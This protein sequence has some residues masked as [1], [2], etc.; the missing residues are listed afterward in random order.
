MNIAN[1][2]KI[3][4]SSTGVINDL[5]WQKKQIGERVYNLGVGEPLMST[6]AMIVDAAV[7]AIKMGWTHYSPVAG[8]PELRQAA[9]NWLNEFYSADYFV[10]EVLIT[11]GGKYALYL[12]IQCLVNPGDE[13]VI[14][15]PFWVSYQSMAE[16]AGGAVKIVET[17]EKSDWKPVLEDIKLK[18]NN[19]TK[20]L[21]LNNASNPTGCLYNCVELKQILQLAREKNFV[22]ISD[23]VYGG[24]AYDDEFISCG[25]FKEYRDNVVIIQS[26]SKNFAMTGWRVG[27]AFGP[28]EIIKAMQTLQSQSI[29]NTSTVSQWAAVTALRDANRIMP[30]I[31]L[32][33]KQRRDL[34]VST[35]N[36]LFAKPIA[37]PAA[38]LYCFVPLAKLGIQGE[39]SIELCRR[40]LAEANVVMVPGGAF[41]KEG[42]VRFSFGVSKEEIVEA[43]GVLAD[44]LR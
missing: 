6:P 7:E 8:I 2:L 27:F 38:A 13:V 34:F 3:K 35:F 19:K 29:T 15:D 17:N 4:P 12:A 31:N 30:Q 44:Y 9:G 33:M 11:C 14:I 39:T 23:E 20:I 5:A 1:R 16:L 36:K 25:S 18:I 28:G 41:G 24:L 22:V 37:A 32:A 42:Y 26:C 40:V 21:I 43:L 10:N